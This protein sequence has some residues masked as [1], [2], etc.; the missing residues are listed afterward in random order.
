MR[1]GETPEESIK[2]LMK[3]ELGLDI[4]PAALRLLGV[5]SY[6]WYRRQQP[7]VENGTCDISVVYSLVVSPEEA[8]GIQLDP[9]EYSETR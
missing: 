2:R 5:H 3:R 8:Q 7:P 6:H 4:A 1:I 9:K